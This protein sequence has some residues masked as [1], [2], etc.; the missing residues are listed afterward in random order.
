MKA[1]QIIQDRDATREQ[2]LDA[3]Q[4]F[5]EIKLAIIND[6][7]NTELSKVGCMGYMGIIGNPDKW[8]T[9]NCVAYKNALDKYRR[10]R[11]Q[12]TICLI[13]QALLD[14]FLKTHRRLSIS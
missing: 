2:I 7:P 8:W 10:A 3:E 11:D 4:I 13:A 5:H 9:D 14:D 1:K 12:N 6:Y